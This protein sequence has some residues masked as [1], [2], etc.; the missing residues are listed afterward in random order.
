LERF[1]LRVIDTRLT[2][3]D[4]NKMNIDPL[5]GGIKLYYE[6]RGFFRACPGNNALHG[7]KMIGKPV[8]SRLI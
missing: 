5:M 2:A 7:S 1:R 3:Q 4:A 8:L 6:V